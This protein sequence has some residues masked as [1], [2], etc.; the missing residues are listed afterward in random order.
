MES[1]FERQEGEDDVVEDA[2]LPSDR[3]GGGRRARRRRRRR[4]DEQDDDPSSYREHRGSDRA[5]F[6][7]NGES[8]DPR[9]AAG[10]SSEPKEARE[11]FAEQPVEVP[12][13]LGEQPSL[14]YG[15]AD[16]E[17]RPGR[18]RRRGRRGG[19]R[20][21]GRDQGSREAEDHDP[22]AHADDTG[23]GASEPLAEHDLASEEPAQAQSSAAADA[24]GE[25]GAHEQPWP[26]G[27]DRFGAEVEPP[28]PA[29]ASSAPASPD[30]GGPEPV[31]A[32]PPEPESEDP[33]RPARKGWWQRRFSGT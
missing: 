27:A 28:R 2:E 16:R 31:H 5:G 25:P 9:L 3:D 12:A 21:R 20:G 8:D 11:E 23:N 33:S 19:R 24:D 14:S 13:G 6:S 30:A 7:A 10:Q 18:R 17:D 22:T 32:Q 29:V 26:T 15:E 1:G 4:R